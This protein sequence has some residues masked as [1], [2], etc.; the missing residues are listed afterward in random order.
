[1][2]YALTTPNSAF[3]PSINR[4]PVTWRLQKYKDYVTGSRESSQRLS[5]AS[6]NGSPN[7]NY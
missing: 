7:P 4:P 1:M 2:I 6:T 5:I 3:K